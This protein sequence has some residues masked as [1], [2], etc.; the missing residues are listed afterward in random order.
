MAHMQHTSTSVSTPDFSPAAF[1]L[2]KACYSV[3]ETLNLLSISRTTFYALVK[4]G[5]IPIAKVGA[6]TLVYA[7]DIAKLLHNLQSAA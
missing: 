3:N 2:T 6:K 7:R 4:S 1:G 5:N